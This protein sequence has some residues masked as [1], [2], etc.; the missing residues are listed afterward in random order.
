M[1]VGVI[2]TGVPIAQMVSDL[3][4]DARARSDGF[5]VASPWIVI[6]ATAV[7]ALGYFFAAWVAVRIIAW[8]VSGFVSDHEKRSN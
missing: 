3:N 8:V 2:A 6:T 1:L 5:V 7:G 4:N